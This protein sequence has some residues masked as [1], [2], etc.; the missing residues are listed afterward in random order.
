MDI[1]LYGETA[2]VRTIQR[3]RAT[4]KDQRV[5]LAVRVTQVW[6]KQQDEWRLVAIQFSSALSPRT[7][8]EF[9][10]TGPSYS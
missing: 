9:P 8:D 10:G 1:I 2:I 4:Y 3:N 5:E 6:V 7:D